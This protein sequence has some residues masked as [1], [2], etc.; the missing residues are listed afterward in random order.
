[1]PRA[2]TIFGIHRF[3]QDRRHFKNTPFDFPVV[4]GR[5]APPAADRFF[6]PVVRVDFCR[7]DKAIIGIKFE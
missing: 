6:V 1:M 4:R 7:P 5:P 2:E 3:E